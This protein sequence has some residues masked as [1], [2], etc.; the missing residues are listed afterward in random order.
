[1]TAPAGPPGGPWLGAA[2]LCERVI[3]D[4]DALSAVHILEQITAAG[5]RPVELTMLMLIVRGAARGPI[6]AQI[7]AR[8]PDGEL[9]A[10]LEVIAD[11][12]ETPDGC[13]RVVVPIRLDVVRDGVYWFD[14]GV[15]DAIATR[16]PLRVVTAR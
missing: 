15:G 14:V 9:V 8:S 4:G 16:V 12:P 6:V 1:V 10:A 7:V 11:L 3:V 13:G 2:V 5:P